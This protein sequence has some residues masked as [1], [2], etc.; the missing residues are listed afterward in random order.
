HRAPRPCLARNREPALGAPHAR[1][2]RQ[3][4]VRAPG[5]SLRRHLHVARLEPALTDALRLPAVAARKPTARLGLIDWPARGGRP[6]VP[7]GPRRPAA[8]RGPAPPIR[9]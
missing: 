6:L 9:E 2:E 8:C 5:R 4:P 3:E 1:G 7:A